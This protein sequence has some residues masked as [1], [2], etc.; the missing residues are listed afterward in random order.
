MLKSTL[1]TKNRHLG[2]A[3]RSEPKTDLRYSLERVE[4]TKA[5]RKAS[6]KE[7]GPMT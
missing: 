6:P 4:R 3:E 5:G 2:P 1:D 7:S